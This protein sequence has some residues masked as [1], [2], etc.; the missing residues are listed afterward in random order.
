MNAITL[1]LRPVYR[2]GYNLEEPQPK[3]YDNEYGQNNHCRYFEL[4]V[5]NLNGNGIKVRCSQRILSLQ[6]WLTGPLSNS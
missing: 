2:T 6:T 5:K 4:P 3:D 1:R